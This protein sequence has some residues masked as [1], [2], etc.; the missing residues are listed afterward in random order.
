MQAIKH[1]YELNIL[2]LQFIAIIQDDR[3][4]DRPESSEFSFKTPLGLIPEEK[5]QQY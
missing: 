5:I 4:A 1:L 2:Y 3:G